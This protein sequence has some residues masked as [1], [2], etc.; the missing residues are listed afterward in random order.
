MSEQVICNKEDL[1]A[2]ADAVRN[3]TSSTET[4]SV[5]ELRVATVA[6]LENS[7]SATAVLYT[8]QTLTDAQKEQARLNIGAGTGDLTSDDLSSAIESALTQAKE[9]GEFD[10]A[11]GA[12]GTSVTVV[13]IS[14]SDLD[15]DENVVT[16]SDG[17]TL[18]V[19][20]GTKG[21]QGKGV[22]SMTQTV[23]S[24][25]D[26]G[27]NVWRALVGT[28]F[29]DLEVKNGSKGSKGDKGDKGDAGLNW[30]GEWS[31]SETY[32]YQD[33]VTYN[34]SAYVYNEQDD[35]APQ[36]TT[37][38]EEDISV[39][40]LLVSKGDTGSAGANGTNGKDGTSVT[41]K[42]VS[43]STADGGSNVVT[44]SDGKTIT[45]KNGSKGSTGETG[46]SGSDGVGIKSV[47]QTTTSSADGGSNVITVTKTDNTTSTFTVKNGSKGSTGSAGKDG[48]SATHSWNGT[49]LTVTSASG[50]SSANLKGDKGDAGDRGHGVHCI[51]TAPSDYTTAT[52][53]FT[54]AYRVALSTVKTQGKTDDVVVGDVIIYKYYT[55]QVG[56]VDASYVY[57]GTRVSI[58]GA[59][60]SDATVTSEN[61]A[62][63]LG[64]TPAK[65]SDVQEL[66]ARIVS[67]VVTMTQI[68]YD[69]MTQSELA[70]LY[71]QGA[72]IIAVTDVHYTN[73]V[74]LS[75]DADGNVYNGT[76]YKDGYRLNSSYLDTPEQSGTTV[77][78]FIPCTYSDI[79]RI[80]GATW[81]LKSDDT[82][83]HFYVCGYD[84][85][86]IPSYAIDADS[87][88]NGLIYG[89]S[90]A[91]DET[92]GVTTFDFSNGSP[93]SAWF[94]AWQNIAYIRI[95]AYGNGED[96]ILTINE[97]I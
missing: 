21:S 81:L 19:K 22:E 15:G 61:I 95:C 27:I 29:Y 8:E 50:T 87:Y 56:Y 51:T 6:A 94:I 4:Y 14:E 33:V 88:I 49:T 40:S 96:L 60:G 46:A 12:D 20:N 62:S 32:K 34:G 9:S 37:P 26:G 31:G 78:G 64:Y 68:Q 77:T 25:E 69:S 3:S 48:T 91:Y 85:S 90:I 83:K 5:P 53:G 38:G 18:T 7:G 93:T 79:I 67:E 42:S 23:K 57:L 59:A 2:I 43:E 39:W 74:P 24:E 80:K 72:R 63:A 10:G 82:A 76:G 11:D 65:D 35:N 55:Y 89:A 1:V 92:T 70:N 41:V 86:K 30:R 66:S 58:R 73:L 44:F 16:F 84:S 28:S 71:A 97:E 54:P 13:S 17:T 36:G 45:I 47:T 75:I 52:G